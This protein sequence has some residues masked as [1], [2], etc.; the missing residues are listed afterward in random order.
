MSTP[1]PFISFPAIFHGGDY[2]PDQWPEDV[3]D[4]DVR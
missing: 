2:N 4:D 1:K 3:W